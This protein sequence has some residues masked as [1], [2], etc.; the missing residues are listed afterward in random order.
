[1]IPDPAITDYVI[2][3]VRM[4]RMSRK[5]RPLLPTCGIPTR[6]MIDHWHRC[7]ALHCTRVHKYTHP[8]DRSTGPRISL[9]TPPSSAI[10]PIAVGRHTASVC[11]GAKS[12]NRR[13]NILVFRN[14]FSFLRAMSRHVT[15]VCMVWYG[16]WMWMCIFIGPLQPS[17]VSS[18]TPAESDANIGLAVPVPTGTGTRGTG[19][20]EHPQNTHGWCD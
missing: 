12:K 5:I 2:T 14:S 19:R 11:R 9:D 20:A 6:P 4:S 16:M 7:Q 13:P 10:R 15:D 8:A 1:M 3:P 18:M 17:P